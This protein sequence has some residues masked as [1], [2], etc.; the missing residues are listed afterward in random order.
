M[1]FAFVMKE[2]SRMSTASPRL[3]VILFDVGGVLVEPSGVATMLSWMNHRVSA[4]EL[5]KLWLTSPTVRA[6][7]T[8]KTSAEDFADCVIAD[9]ALPVTRSVFLAELPKWSTTPFPGALHLVARLPS[10]YIRAT[11]CNTNPVHWACLMNNAALA[12]AFAHHF[13][14]HLTGKIKP[15]ADAFL[16][17]TRTL[18]CPPDEVLFLDDNEMNVA[19]A[20][21]TGMKAIR[22]KGP[23]EAER[24]LVSFGVLGG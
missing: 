15:D 17:V 5:W 10:R 22:V 4:E 11:L 20:I 13:A 12:G 7:E 3:R 21:A 14:S 1:S 19:G 23:A 24:A 6:F 18:G 9:F 2:K 16:H 8:G